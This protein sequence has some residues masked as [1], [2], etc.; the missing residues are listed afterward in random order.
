MNGMQGLVLL[1]TTTTKRKSKSIGIHARRGRRRLL[2]P[3]RTR[4]TQDYHLVKSQVIV[5]KRV[6]VYLFF[7]PALW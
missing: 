2:E 5:A 4:P 1:P 3:V 7:I 6:L